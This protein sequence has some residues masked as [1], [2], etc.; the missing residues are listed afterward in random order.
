MYDYSVFSPK[1]DNYSRNGLRKTLQGAVWTTT[2]QAWGLQDQNRSGKKPPTGKSR[3]KFPSSAPPPPLP[4]PG[5]EAVD[6][7]TRPRVTAFSRPARLTSEGG[8]SPAARRWPCCCQA[9][10][11]PISTRRQRRPAFEL[12]TATSCCLASTQCNA[13]CLSALRHK[14][15]AILWLSWT[16]TKMPEPPRAAPYANYRAAPLFHHQSTNGNMGKGI[17]WYLEFRF[18]CFQPS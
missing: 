18:I 9:R 12:G 1:E 6:R 10:R 16:C 17:F 15:T 4:G 14:G 8:D 11:Q 13:V 7:R 2:G 5:Q 3:P